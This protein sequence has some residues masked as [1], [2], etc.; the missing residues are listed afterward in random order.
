MLTHVTCAE[1]FH[2]FLDSALTLATII[3]AGFTLWLVLETKSA[4]KKQLGVNSWL[5]FVNRWESGEMK[6]A[7][8][9]L[10]SQFQFAEETRT[11]DDTVLDFF[12][13]VGTTYRTECI[14]KQLVYSS[15]SWDAIHWW[16]ALEKYIKGMRIEYDDKTTYEDFEALALAMKDPLPSEVGLTQYLKD[17]VELG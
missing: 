1:I 16:A 7:R 4:A 11:M 14:D 15:F 6:K 10:A 12:E 13:Q 3:L 17:E 2:L 5:Y 8:S 9:K